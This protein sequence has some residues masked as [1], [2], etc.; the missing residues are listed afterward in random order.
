MKKYLFGLLAITLAVGFS[1]FTTKKASKPFTDTRYY[2][3]G[4]PQKA[5]GTTTGQT[6]VGLNSVTAPELSDAGNY[7]LSATVANINSGDFLGAIEFQLDN[8]AAD[9]NDQALTICEAANA[10]AAKFTAMGNALP[11]HDGTFTETATGSNCVIK[12]RRAS[13]CY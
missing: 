1:A 11:G 2:W 10:V 3:I 12:I 6:P 7:R 13:S 9:G 4:D 5:F 8:T